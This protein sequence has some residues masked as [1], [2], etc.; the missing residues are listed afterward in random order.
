MARKL[1]TALLLATTPACAQSLQAV[2]AVA[3]Y[4]PLRLPFTSDWC[5]RVGQ[6]L[7]A[8]VTASSIESTTPSLA[9]GIYTYVTPSVSYLLHIANVDPVSATAYAISASWPAPISVIT[10]ASYIRLDNGQFSIGTMPFAPYMIQTKMTC[11]IGAF[12]LSRTE[13]N[14]LAQINGTP[15]MFS[16]PPSI[17][18][19]Q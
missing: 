7:S 5:T 11:T 15:Y 2:Q 18:V 9:E 4:E 10:G 13:V 6:T 19:T 12:T 16:A 8:S 14:V 1:L 3:E 17:T